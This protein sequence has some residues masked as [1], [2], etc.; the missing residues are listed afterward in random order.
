MK[1]DKTNVPDVNYRS[2]LY[3][4]IGRTVRYLQQGIGTSRRA[5]KLSQGGSPYVH[6]C[7]TLERYVGIIN[8]FRDT[9]LT[10]VKTIN[11]ITTD[12]VETHFQNLLE[13]DVTEK[14]IK[15]NASA[16]I[17]L[18]GALNRDDLIAY[19]N[20]NRYLWVSSARLSCRTNPFGDPDRV[21]GFM[22]GDPYKAGAIIQKET[23]TRVSDIKKVVES[24]LS[25]PSSNIIY[26]KKS[27]GGRDR[28][29]NFS[30]RK[31][32]LKLVRQAV[33][34]IDKHFTETKT[35]WSQFLKEY[36]KEVH[37]A[38]VKAGE[39]YCGPHAFRANYAETRYETMITDKEDKQQEK[40]V[41]KKITKELGHSRISMAKYYIPTFRS[42]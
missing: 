41:L 4:A 19:I 28:M 23:G 21:I 40:A 17:K 31:D 16:L 13:K 26:I 24:V 33:C 5:F 34:T 2:G 15:V 37:R 30:D 8:N 25:N 1:H 7:E 39:I 29:I 18:F 32:R 35:N 11:K 10:D 42:D 36:T 9:V 14:T 20:K 27:K 22:R 6:S 3:Y 38:V 12:H